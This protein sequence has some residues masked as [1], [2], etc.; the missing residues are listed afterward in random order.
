[1]TISPR[2]D[3]DPPA[4]AGFGGHEQRATRA[5]LDVARSIN[6]AVEPGE[7]FEVA[8][9]V[10]RELLD[11]ERATILL[12]DS[13]GQ[14]V[15]QISVARV[16]DVELWRRFRD[17]PPIPA[18]DGSLARALLERGRAVRI[19]DAS[20]S[21]LVPP[22]WQRAF[23]LTSLAVVPLVVKG[24]IC[25]ALAVDDSHGPRPFDDAALATLEGLA[26]LTAVIAHT[27]LEATSAA[28]QA[29]RQH[30]VLALAAELAEA[31]EP[32]RVLDIGLSALTGLFAAAGCGLFALD[33]PGGGRVLAWRVADRP[34][35]SDTR[36][37]LSAEQLCQLRA[38]WHTHPQETFLLRRAGEP[39][40]GQLPAAPDGQLLVLP[41]VD[42]RQ[43]QGY[44]VLAAPTVNPDPDLLRAGTLTAG[45]V[46]QALRRG[47]RDARLHHRLQCLEALYQLT[48]EIALLPQMRLVIDR[49]APVVRSA[50]GVEL[51]DVRLCNRSAARLF[52]T[53]TAH[54]ELKAL[55]RRW[56]RAAGRPVVVDGLHVLPLL[57]DEHLIGIMQVRST[58]ARELTEDGE[59]F[60][61]AVAAELAEV[62]SRAVLRH[63]VEVGER[64]LAVAEERYRIAGELYEGVSHLLVRAHQ[65]LRPLLEL[66]PVVQRQRPA[67]RE[68]VALVGQAISYAR[69]SVR[70]LT[71]LP[72]NID[73]LP[74][75]L[76]HLVND[77][78]ATT[79]A[80][81][82]FRLRGSPVPLSATDDSA[83]L[84]VAHTSL[85]RL[86]AGARADQVGVELVYHE[87]QV[88][89]RIWDNGVGLWQRAATQLATHSTIR[90]MTVRMQ[91]I[92]GSLAMSEGEVGLEMVATL[93]VGVDRPTPLRPRKPAAV[94]TLRR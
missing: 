94:R 7:A 27:A 43:T 71:L 74:A 42:Q 60:L 51:I 82:T 61:L 13:H 20:Q 58:G 9:R 57:L 16:E 56:H 36:W 24:E 83:L 38:R 93:R 28:V 92:G 78:S 41:C 22:E 55:M 64:E 52:E 33:E 79:Q 18:D 80:T 86:Q 73:G 76:R 49:L 14:L 4:P 12:L 66:P 5:L 87:G 65:T 40:A 88:Q 48:Q 90:T 77:W 30:R 91:E 75:S 44:L 89:L 59:R 2:L 8:V 37:E 72:A 54:G 11:A 46:W 15:P 68:G 6:T 3:P 47:Q 63:R 45:L 10:A 62:V 81:V 19:E 35:T 29:D 21:C 34:V 53:P 69:A 31:N 26:A 50:A 39:Q 23:R 25:G 85:T 1:M 67:L 17:M 32:D 84:H 70:S